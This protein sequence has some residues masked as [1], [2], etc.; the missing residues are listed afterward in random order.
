MIISKLAKKLYKEVLETYYNQDR[1]KQKAFSVLLNEKLKYFNDNVKDVIT[2]DINEMLKN[3]FGIIDTSKFKI[4]DID[5]S[6][7]LHKNSKTIET[8][9]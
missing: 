8:A 4:D 1:Y 7:L 5:L 6:E 3:E 2:K 9:T